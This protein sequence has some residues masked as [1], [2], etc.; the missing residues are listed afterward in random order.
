[1]VN[2]KVQVRGHVK[3]RKGKQHFQLLD[4]EEISED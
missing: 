2:R 4:I 1:M 3:R